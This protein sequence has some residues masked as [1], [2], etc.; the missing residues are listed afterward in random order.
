MT[1]QVLPELTGSVTADEALD[2][3]RRLSATPSQCG[4]DDENGVARV[5]QETLGAEGVEVDLLEVS[6]GRPN[7]FARIPGRGEA[8]SL[9][10]NGHMDTTP[11]DASWSTGHQVHVDGD[12]VRAHGARNMKG[13]VASIVLALLAWQRSGARPPGDLL[14][15]AVM[16]HHQ[17]GLGTR[18]LMRQIEWP[19]HTI[20]PE[21]TDLKIRTVQ[22]G[23][24]ALRIRVR[25]RTAPVGDNALFSR[26]ARRADQARN[27]L[28]VVDVVNRSLMSVPYKFVADERVPDLPMTQVRGVS[29]GYGENMLSMAFAPDMMELNVGVYTTKGQKP[30]RVRDEVAAHLRA[31]LAPFGLHADIELVGSF[32]DFLDVPLD[33]PVVES[34]ERAHHDVLGTEATVGALLPHSYFGCDGQILAMEGI[35]A[36]S[37]GPGSHAYRYDSRGRVEIPHVVACARAL[38]LTPLRLAERV[39]R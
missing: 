16:G 17:G 12:V 19:Q 29:V 6:A 3:T 8:P 38:A 28:D 23:S 5:L 39:D 18:A 13:G 32:R 35:D 2:L 27:P 33:A 26:Y 22:T 37:Y 36:I 31:V 25:G 7:V 24:L 15:T 9:M 14:F 11:F 34:L 1:Q 10:L 20:I 30:D 4:V 21:P